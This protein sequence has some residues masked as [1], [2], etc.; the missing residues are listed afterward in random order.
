MKDSNIYMLPVEQL[1]N[2]G[3]SIHEVSRGGDVTYHGPGQIVGYPIMDL[4]NFG[5]DIKDFVWK[6]RD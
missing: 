6:K 5:K 1:R 4:N 2:K 3:I